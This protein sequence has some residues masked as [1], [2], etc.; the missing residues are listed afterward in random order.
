M[1]DNKNGQITRGRRSPRGER[2][3]QI[4]S[5]LY[6]KTVEKSCFLENYFT[7][8]KFVKSIIRPI[9]KIS[10]IK[11]FVE[12]FLQGLHT[13]LLILHKNID[14]NRSYLFKRR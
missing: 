13:N 7:K 11:Y 9:S 5:V 14:I 3:P 6:M 12:K 1:H 8:K 2:D 10:K 4:F